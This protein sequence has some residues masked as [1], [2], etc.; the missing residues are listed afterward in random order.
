MEHKL[1]AAVKK[2]KGIERDRAAVAMERDAVRCGLTAVRI[3][4]S[5]I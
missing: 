2:G 1:C 5:M 3:M 4:R